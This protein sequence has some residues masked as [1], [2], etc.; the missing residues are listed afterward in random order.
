MDSAGGDRWPQT[1]YKASYTKACYPY[2]QKSGTKTFVSGIPQK[3][4]WMAII[5]LGTVFEM[6][7]VSQEQIGEE[8]VYVAVQMGS[9]QVPK[10]C[11]QVHE[12]KQ[13][14]GG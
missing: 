14:Q 1:H 13:P 2:I 8:E 4:L 6:K 3:R 12:Q 10:H 7:H 11:D 5:I 9:E